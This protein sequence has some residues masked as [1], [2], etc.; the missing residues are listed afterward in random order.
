VGLR[1]EE[2]LR[3][4][5][6]CREAGD[7]DGALHWWSRL[8]EARFDLVR[9]LVDRRAGRFGFSADEREEAV[10]RSLVKLWNKMLHSFQGTTMGE[11]VN[12]TKSLVEVVCLDVQRDA[13]KR[14]GRETSFDVADPERTNPDWKG[15][16][17]AEETYRRDAEK[18]EAEGFIAWALPQI[19]DE[20][21]RLVLEQTL[22][23]VPAEEI[24]TELGVSMANLYAIRSRGIKDLRR[25]RDRYEA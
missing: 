13:A 10:Q 4:F 12:S 1:D 23:G 21:R 2:L 8:V 24:A 3:R 16:A 5:V 18:G 9:F 7:G 25:L 19:D 11:W 15:A 20:R 22:D 17:K 14:T 6:A